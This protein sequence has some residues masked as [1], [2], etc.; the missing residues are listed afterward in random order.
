MDLVMKSLVDEVKIAR[1]NYDNAEYGYINAATYDLLAAEEKLNNY[2]REKKH[3]E[4]RE[5][6]FQLPTEKGLR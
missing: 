1:Q 2:I 4:I 3:N 5:K 6:T